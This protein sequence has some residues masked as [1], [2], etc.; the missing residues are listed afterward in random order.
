MLQKILVLA[1]SAIALA[2]CQ[3]VA[4]NDGDHARETAVACATSLG[5]ENPG[6]K[7][8][9]G[10][11]TNT[12]T[13]VYPATGNFG[14]GVYKKSDAVDVPYVTVRNEGPRGS[15]WLACMASSGVD[16]SKIKL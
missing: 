7:T 2:S 13:T 16:T 15:K 11:W 1:C 4:K 14:K 5:K 3:T 8:H 6:S 12:L 10:T 9:I